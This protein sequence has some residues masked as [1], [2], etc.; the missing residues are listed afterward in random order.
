MRC[1]A[2]RSPDDRTR[3]LLR[4]PGLVGHEPPVIRPHDVS[5]GGEACAAAGR[6]LYLRANVEPTLELVQSLPAR[7]IDCIDDHT[8]G[9]RPR[10]RRD[11]GKHMIF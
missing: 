1:G 9:D 11:A 10:P 2:D 6:H 8:L 3:R 7:R 4:I 5:L